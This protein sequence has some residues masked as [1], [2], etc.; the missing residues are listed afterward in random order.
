MLVLIHLQLVDVMKKKVANGTVE[1]DV[2]DWNTRVALEL[3]GQGGLGHSFNCLDEF[4]E[5]PYTSALKN[6]V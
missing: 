6:F 2:L 4:S 5:S 1:I 3:V